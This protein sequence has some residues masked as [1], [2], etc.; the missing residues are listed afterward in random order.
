M[1]VVFSSDVSVTPQGFRAEWAFIDY[2]SCRDHCGYN[3][4]L[5]SCTSS[6]Q[7]YGNCCNDYYDYCF[8]TTTTTNTTTTTTTP[9]STTTESSLTAARVD[10]SSDSMNIA[11]RKSYLDSLGFSWYD[12]YLDDHRCRASTDN[13]YVTFN[14]PLHSCST[15]RKTENGRISYTSNVRAAQSTSGEITRHDTEFLL[16]VRCLMER[17]SSVGTLYEAKEITNATISGTATFT[18]PSPIPRTE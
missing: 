6:C 14:F 1:T 18:T 12:L 2:I 4:A 13:Y 11:I 3:G 5:C 17:D 16:V 8:P 10:C 9:E 15:R 7:T